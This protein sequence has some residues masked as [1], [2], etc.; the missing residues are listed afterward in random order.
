M[1]DI[2]DKAS[3]SFYF[4]STSSGLT[5]DP[6]RFS[7]VSFS[8]SGEVGELSYSFWFSSVGSIIDILMLGTGTLTFP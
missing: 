5:A 1:N 4:A 7:E 3:Y 6:S 8:S 2:S